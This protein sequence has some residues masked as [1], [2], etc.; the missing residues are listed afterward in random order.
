MGGGFGQPA[1]SWSWP[2][3]VKGSALSLFLQKQNTASNV[4][5]KVQ[6]STV[7]YCIVLYLSIRKCG[8]GC[9]SLMIDD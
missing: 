4:M 9:V 8:V 7:L 3:W 5:V 1:W 2:C 6:G